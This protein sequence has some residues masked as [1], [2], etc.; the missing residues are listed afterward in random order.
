M[1]EDLPTAVAPQIETGQGTALPHNY[2]AVAMLDLL[3]LA[4]YSAVKFRFI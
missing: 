3:Q 2:S 4:R 1:I